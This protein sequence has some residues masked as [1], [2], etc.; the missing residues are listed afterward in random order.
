M[1]TDEDRQLAEE[2]ESALRAL[3]IASLRTQHGAIAPAV[4]DLRGESIAATQTSAGG[5]DHSRAGMLPAKGES[6]GTER[7]APEAPAAV[8]FGTRQRSER[9]D[10]LTGPDE[11]DQGTEWGHPSG[12][13]SQE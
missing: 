9:H 5:D 8:F 12:S 1:R 4:S 6:G 13:R 3:G 2:V 7:S 11:P 10:P